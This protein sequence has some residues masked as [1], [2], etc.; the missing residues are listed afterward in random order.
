[1]SRDV[2][3]K[4]SCC[5]SLYISY[6]AGDWPPLFVTGDADSE[7]GI[8]ISFELAKGLS[9]PVQAADLAWRKGKGISL[10]FYALAGELCSQVTA[11]RCHPKALVGLNHFC[12]LCAGLSGHPP[13]SWSLACSLM[14]WTEV[15]LTPCRHAACAAGGTEQGGAGGGGR[16]VHLEKHIWT[17]CGVL[18]T[19]TCQLLCAEA[20]AENQTLL[21]LLLCCNFLL[22]PQG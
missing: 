11:S 1:M 5:P 4:N 18:S 13:L 6:H 7:T 22:M 15:S 2:G 12:R 3:Q 21:A 10:C 16:A 17:S 8:S 20:I 19:W 14:P 9:S